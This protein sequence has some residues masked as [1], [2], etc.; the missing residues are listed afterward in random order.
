MALECPNCRERVS[1]LRAFFTPAGGRF[2]CRACGSILGINVV[3]RI[4]VL[5]PLTLVCLYIAYAIVRPYGL[6]L[7]LAVYV[8]LF[9]ICFSLLDKLTLIERRAF[10]CRQ[11]GY[12]LTGLTENRCPECGRTF[13]PAEREVILA[14]ATAPSPRMH[15][16]VILILALAVALTLLAVYSTYRYGWRPAIRRPPATPAMTA[17]AAPSAPANAPT[18]APANTP[19][20]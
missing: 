14:R 11:C 2:Q 4:F 20:D 17:T 15:R 19:G 13:D 18:P 6:L 16:G 1:F 3:R 12:D 10:C 8:A 5:V 9:V 7:T